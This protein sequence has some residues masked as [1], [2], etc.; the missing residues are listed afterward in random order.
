MCATQTQK[1][2]N[3]NTHLAD[4]EFVTVVVAGQIGQNASGT[5]HYINVITAQQLDQGPQE[6]LHSLLERR[7]D[8][9][10]RQMR[11]RKQ[12][13]SVILHINK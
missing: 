4:H 8:S 9:K 3:T 13:F 7:Q 12:T 11:R 6:T 2:V 10:D 1:D 5:C